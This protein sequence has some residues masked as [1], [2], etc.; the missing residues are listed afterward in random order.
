MY[1]N[2]TQATA[3]IKLNIKLIYVDEEEVKM[4]AADEVSY[5]MVHINKQHSIYNILPMRINTVSEFII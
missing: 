3:S 4:E 2:F 1:S 5:K